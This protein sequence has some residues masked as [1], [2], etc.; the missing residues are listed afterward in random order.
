MS[1]KWIGKS[2]HTLRTCIPVVR[3]VAVCWEAPSAYSIPLLRVIYFNITYLQLCD[4]SVLSHN[5]ICESI[6]GRRDFVNCLQ[7]QQQQQQCRLYVGFCYSLMSPFSLLSLFIAWETIGHFEVRIIFAK[8]VSFAFI[9]LCSEALFYLSECFSARI[10]SSLLCS[11]FLTYSLSLS[12]SRHA[13]F[14]FHYSANA[15][16][17]QASV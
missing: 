8:S 14:K 17:L 6:F 5:F 7:S 11:R 12:L 9:S 1:Q 4:I 2:K 10:F 13:F 16:L 3:T 15:M